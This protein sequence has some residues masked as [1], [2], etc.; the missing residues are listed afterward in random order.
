MMFSDI[1]KKCDVAFKDLKEDMLVIEKKLKIHTM[2]S[3]KVKKRIKEKPNAK[4]IELNSMVDFIKAEIR[5]SIKN[6]LGINEK[7]EFSVSKDNY[8]VTYA[9][10]E[11]PVEVRKMM[12][13]KDFGNNVETTISFSFFNCM[14][15]VVV[16][17]FFKFNKDTYVSSNGF[18][19]MQDF[20]INLDPNGKKP[21]HVFSLFDD[22]PN[23]KKFIT[24][25]IENDFSSVQ[26]AL[27]MYLL[28]NDINVDASKEYQ[29]MARA[30]IAI[31]NTLKNKPNS[32]I[33]YQKI[34]V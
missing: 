18:D 9:L 26:D 30:M 13:I 33:D 22:N 28:S 19:Q 3:R 25:L 32:K 8:S 29:E 24:F 5:D 10:K 4:K 23:E 16:D 14:D 21:L 27:D 2:L 6:K 34:K 31:N 1:K 11:L 12:T 7:I 15:T 20:K 17:L